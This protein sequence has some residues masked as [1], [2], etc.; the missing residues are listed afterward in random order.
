MENTKKISLISSYQEE[1]SQF[2]VMIADLS[3]SKNAAI[4]KE[5]FQNLSID[6]NFSL[7]KM[8]KLKQKLN[9]SNSEGPSAK[10]DKNGQLITTK[11][12]LL[13]LYEQE[14]RERL[15]PMPPHPGYETVKQIQEYLFNLRLRIGTSRKS[16]KWTTDMLIKVCNKLKN[17]KARDLDGLIYELF[18]PGRCG[19]DVYFSLT[20]MF[21]TIKSSQLI[22]S[23]LQTMSITS[24]YKSKGPK[25]SLNSQ[26]GIF[27]LSKVR[28]LLDKLLYN[29]VYQTV[30]DSLSC[31][32]AGGRKERGCR[33]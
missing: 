6:G 11:N 21:N 18:K 13:N 14:Y 2:D 25:N 29:D 9:L 31:S 20:E 16:Q 15:A 30:D 32:N 3:A 4:I 24:I 5:H 26:R 28:S 1:V 8:W 33:D 27:N 23:F 19:N 7:T 17:K 12:G 22:P 10:I